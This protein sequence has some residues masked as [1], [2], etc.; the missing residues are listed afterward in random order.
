MLGRPVAD[1]SAPLPEAARTDYVGWI[2]AGLAI[3]AIFVV[4]AAF[5]FKYHP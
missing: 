4:M 3:L 5:W 2:S 1:A